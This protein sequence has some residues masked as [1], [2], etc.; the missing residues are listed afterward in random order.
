MVIAKKW[1]L[2]QPS[3]GSPKLSDFKLN[4][5]K[6]KPIEDGEICKPKQGKTVVVN[7]AGGAVGSHVVQIAKI[8]VNGEI[9]TTI[10]NQMNTF[11]RV[12]LCG[13]ISGYNATE[14]QKLPYFVTVAKQLI[15]QSFIVM[16]WNGR[17]FEGIHANLKWI[18]EGKLKHRD[19]YGRIR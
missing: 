12:S 13:A 7:G 15:L 4:E 6:L 8:K 1:A 10:L 2:V 5:E 17:W 16:K 19:N 11:G 9:S 14:I 3:K 18:Q